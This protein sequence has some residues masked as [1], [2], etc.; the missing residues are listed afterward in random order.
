MNPT[1]KSV[2]TPTNRLGYIDLLKGVAITLMVMGHSLWGVPLSPNTERD[3]IVANVIYSFHMPLFMFLS[4]YVLDLNGSR[5]WTAAALMTICKRR[6]V[7]LLLPGG[8]F[9]TIRYFLSG[10]II[11]PWFLR[12]L[13]EITILYC[14][15][16]CLAQRYKLSEKWGLLLLCMGYILVFALKHVLGDGKASSLLGMPYWQIFYPYFVFGFCFRRYALQRFLPRTYTIAL[17][18]FVLLLFAD[19]CLSLPH[20]V[21]ALMTYVIAA[22][23]ITVAYTLARKTDIATSSL[24]RLFVVLGIS[25]LNI[26]LL[27]DFFLPHFQTMGNMIA[28]TAEMETPYAAET[29]CLQIVLSVAVTAYSIAMS[30]AVTKII[31]PSKILNLLCFGKR[32]SNG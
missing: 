22:C 6:A 27:S 11:F 14:A 15:I 16:M 23:G 5:K 18:A 2:D 31:E 30:M 28:V 21:H 26:Y 25:S 24:A 7:T 19:N 12:A 13:F 1:Y 20:A 3:S 4:G 9:L 10:E 17:V 32:M 8:V 29:I